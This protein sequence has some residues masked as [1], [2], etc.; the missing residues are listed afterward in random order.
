MAAPLLASA[1]IGK[2]HGVEGFVRVYSLSGETAHLKKLKSCVA[3]T[4]E[5][6]ELSLSIDNVKELGDYLLMK[7]TGYENPEKARFLVK[8]TILIPR[9][10]APQLKDGEYYVA[11]LYGM[12]VI[13]DGRKVGRVEYTMEGAQALLIA[14]RRLDNEREYLVP[15]LPVYVTDISPENNSLVLLYPELLEL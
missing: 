7:F 1:T 2:T 9:E 3:R 15:D 6:E 10:D 5:G 14:V 4:S 11:D 13:Y 12:D 8:A